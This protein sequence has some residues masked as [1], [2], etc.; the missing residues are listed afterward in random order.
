M[1]CWNCGKNI[2]NNS[3]ECPFCGELIEENNTPKEEDLEKTIAI[4]KA[5]EDTKGLLDLT[6]INDIKSEI[7]KLNKQNEEIKE[8]EI[9]EENILEDDD[10]E[11][12]LDLNSKESINERKRIFFMVGIV[13]FLLF[14]IIILLIVFGNRGNTVSQE[15][16][17]DNSSYE[18]EL[19]KSL[20]NYYET[21]E[22]DEVIYIVESVKN[23]SEK[24]EKVHDITSDKCKEWLKTYK[25]T[26]DDNKKEFSESTTNYKNIIEGLNRY[27]IT[28]VGSSY[29]KA[30]SNED[31][32][33]FI[34]EIDTVYSDGLGFYDALSYY[35]KKD[36]NKA[37]ALLGAIEDTNSFYDKANSYKNK[38][39]S[40]VISILKKDIVKVSK[41][42]DSLSDEDKLSKYIQIEELILKYDNIYTNLNLK[43]N[44]DYNAILSEY[45]DKIEDLSN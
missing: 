34:K 12:Y 31:Y 11:G 33:K 7:D 37:Y 5:N 38:I 25:E 15:V 45:R 30:L 8:E 4:S 6:L 32:D 2:K 23:D 39:I 3:I 41:N 24:I 42:I 21:K 26:L 16:N 27:A 13:A 1:K 40:N 36:Y 35:N 22:I 20:D 18:T 9:K 19:V 28:K 43:S 14:F 10:D 29:I 44:K 17:H